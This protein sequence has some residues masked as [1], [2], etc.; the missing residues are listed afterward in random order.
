MTAICAALL[1]MHQT[2]NMHADISRECAVLAW[3]CCARDWQLERHGGGLGFGE[4]T[5]APNGQRVHCGRILAGIFNDGNMVLVGS[6]AS[7]LHS[8]PLPIRKDKR[9]NCARSVTI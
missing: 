9:R 5:H 6:A 4:L 3:F 1:C 7:I 2:V 8:L